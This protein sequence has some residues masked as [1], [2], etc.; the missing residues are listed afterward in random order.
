MDYG[1]VM[2]EVHVFVDHFRRHGNGMASLTTDEDQLKRVDH[3][4]LAV[5]TTTSVETQEIGISRPS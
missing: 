1:T 4:R 3:G 2:T 5:T